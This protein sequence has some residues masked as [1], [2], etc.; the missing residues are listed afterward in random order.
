[1]SSAAFEP[2]KGKVHVQIL[3][4]DPTY[5]CVLCHRLTPFYMY[6]YTLEIRILF[7]VKSTI[8]LLAPGTQCEPTEATSAAPGKVGRGEQR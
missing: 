5:I 6:E 7:W 3:C 1:M 4:A 2:G 8:L